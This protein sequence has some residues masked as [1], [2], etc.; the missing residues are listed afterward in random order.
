MLLQQLSNRI[1]YLPHSSATDRPALGYIKGDHFPLMVDTGNSPRHLAQMLAGVS[2]RGLPLPTLAAVTHWHWDHTFAI[3]AFT[4]QTI[5]SRL[6]NQQ[7]KVMEGWRWTE[8]AMTHRLETG[9]EIEFCDTHMRLEYPD[10][11]EIK[12]TAADIVFENTLTLDLGGVCCELSLVGGPHSADSVLVYLPQDRVL[13]AGDAH[14]GDFYGKGGEY[15]KEK[16]S[17][18]TEK[19]KAIPFE[20]YLHGHCEPMTRAEIFAELAAL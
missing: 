1:Y 11:S 16:L 18:F 17:D 4:G 20:T 6:T 8:S 15:D 7:L 12:V 13:F 9:V 5:A 14:S 2:E 10:P 19:L 3:S